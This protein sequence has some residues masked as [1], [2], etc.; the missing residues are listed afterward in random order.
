MSFN[1]QIQSITHNHRYN[2]AKSSINPPS[3]I[4]AISFRVDLVV[5]EVQLVQGPGRRTDPDGQ[6]AGGRAGQP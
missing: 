4:P 2:I 5:R 1:I 3:A 6:H